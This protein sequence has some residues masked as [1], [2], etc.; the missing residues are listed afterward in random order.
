M[1]EFGRAAFP[2]VRA[3]RKFM[4]VSFGASRVVLLE[5][6]IG[7]RLK[8]VSEFRHN[9]HKTDHRHSNVGFER[10]ACGG[11]DGPSVGFGAK[12]AAELCDF[13]QHFTGVIG[14]PCS[15]R[16]FVL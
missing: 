13:S 2:Q 16:W 6:S 4:S 14:Y 10:L 12:F 5:K 15:I 8:L 1:D 7:S 11:T 9:H 3:Q